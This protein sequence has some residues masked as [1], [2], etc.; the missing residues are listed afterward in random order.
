VLDWAGLNTH[1]RDDL[2]GMCETSAV[3]VTAT[4]T[5]IPRIGILLCGENL[6]LSWIKKIFPDVA[7]MK[8]RPEIFA[9]SV[10]RYRSLGDA[11]A[12]EAGVPVIVLSSEPTVE[13]AKLTTMYARSGIPF[14]IIHLSDEYGTDGSDDLTW[15]AHQ[16]C[17]R[18]YRN[19]IYP[20]TLEQFPVKSR[21]KIFVFPLGPLVFRDRDWQ[22]QQGGTVPLL[23][24]RELTWSFAGR[25]KHTLREDEIRPYQAF[26]P[27]ELFFFPYFL[28]NEAKSRNDYIESLLKSKCI[29]ILRGSNLETFRLYE[30]VEFGAV[31]IY[32][33]VDGDGAYFRFLRTLFPAIKDIRD[34]GEIFR[35]SVEELQEY[36]DSLMKSWEKVKKAPFVPLLDLFYDTKLGNGAIQCE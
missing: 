7:F 8:M 32:L 27:N 14:D 30:A 3:A 34:P 15:Y 29:P 21:Q 16:S 33:R 26:G 19:Y 13:F 18:I 5:T 12:A 23:E 28:D 24:S 22:W 4:P 6:E 11:A 10:R 36:A 9:E 35:M 1:C 2:I 31:P 20:R 25:V 17:R